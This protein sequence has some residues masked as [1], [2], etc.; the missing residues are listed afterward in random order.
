MIVFTVKVPAL[1]AS[2]SH[3][4]RTP[5]FEA[6]M[7]TRIEAAFDAANRSP[8]IASTATGRI[9][10]VAAVTAIIIIVCTTAIIAIIRTIT[11][12]IAIAVG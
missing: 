6:L 4:G 5:H 12:T 2:R 11:A 8:Q 10:I 1:L 3:T 7:R 9:S